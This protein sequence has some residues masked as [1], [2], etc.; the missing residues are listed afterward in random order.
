M[1]QRESNQISNVVWGI[2]KQIAPLFE[3]KEEID[4]D[5]ENF[6]TSFDNTSSHYRMQLRNE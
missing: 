5:S 4:L 6:Y 2:V 1:M 3:P